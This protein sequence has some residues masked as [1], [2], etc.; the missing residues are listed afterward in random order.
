MFKRI[1]IN[2]KGPI[3]QC[4]KKNLGWN[5]SLVKN[6]YTLVIQCETCLTTLQ[7]GPDQCRAY[8]NLDQEYPEGNHP[9]VDAKV[10]KLVPEEKKES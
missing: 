4:P 2:L 6:K 8:F 1:D 7:V 10:L 3:C 5:I 9:R